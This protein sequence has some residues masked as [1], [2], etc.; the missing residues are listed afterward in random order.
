M[1]YWIVV[2]LALSPSAWAADRMPWKITQTEWTEADEKDYEDF[3][4]KIGD[5]GC[6]TVDKCMKGLGNRKEFRDTDPAGVTWY[7]DCADFPYFLRAYY[8]LKK[9]LP[10]TH[11]SSMSK[12]PDPPYNNSLR[13]SANGNYVTDRRD[14]ISPGDGETIDG[15]KFIH[16][17]T[18]MISSAM[19]RFPPEEDKAKKWVDFYPVAITRESVKAGTIIYDPDG[20]VG[21]VYKVTD[22]GQVHI[23][24]AHP[25]N[26]L[27]HKMYGEAIS[28]TRHVGMGQGFKRWRPIKLVGA[29]LGVDGGYYGGHYEAARNSELKDFSDEQYYGTEKARW[30]AKEWPEFYIN[31]V[32]VEGRKDQKTGVESRGTAFYEYVRLKLAKVGFK[33]DPVQEVALMADGLCQDLIYRVQAVDEAIAA[34]A[35]QKKHP[36]RLPRNIYATE[37]DWELYSTP[38]RDARLKV[39]FQELREKTQSFVE[40]FEAQDPL[41]DY[42]GKDLRSDLAHAYWDAVQACTINYKRSD[43]TEQMLS[44]E[45]ARVRLFKMSFDPYHCVELR[46]GATDPQELATCK[47]TS[48][49]DRWYAA[50]QRLR[51]QAERTYGARMDF[52]VKELE[53]KA[54]GSGWDEAPDTDVLAYLTATPAH[55]D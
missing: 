41:I 22:N 13:G 14:V 30:K 24:D 7:S 48:D 10:F 36:A 49:K 34:K 33:Y 12:Y 6:N 45:Q 25:G 38:S 5:S 44:L 15:N 27:S 2:A 20:H 1:Q 19:F 42:K 3:V 43:G 11:A 29:R 55:Q 51:N 40:R 37:G 9:H 8:A 4:F 26:S 47:S 52:G 54:K 50:E 32:R 23:I 28:V 17:L 18:G 31:G 39:S 16:T 46:W 21:V 35:D 53:S